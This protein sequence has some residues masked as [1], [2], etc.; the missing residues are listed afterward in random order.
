MD[1][2]STF[3]QFLDNAK[4]HNPGFPAKDELEKVCCCV[5]FG[6]GPVS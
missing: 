3:S 6:I 2:L 5:P 4:P 1:E